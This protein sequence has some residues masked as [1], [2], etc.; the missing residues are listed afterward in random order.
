MGNTQFKNMKTENLHM[1]IC[2]VSGKG[3]SEGWYI[4]G[5]Y[6]STKSLADG[7]AKTV[8]KNADD[9]EWYEDFKELYQ[10]CLENGETDFGY[11]TEWYEYDLEDEGEAYD[12]DGNLYEFKNNQWVRPFNLEDYIIVDGDGVT[13]EIWAHKE[14]KKLIE[15]PIEIVEIVRDL[16][17]IIYR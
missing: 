8:R 16:D 6:L 9:L 11:W 17:N 12:D 7:Y 10:D 4:N 2:S 13:V 1:H 14:T 15:I 5:E 3:M